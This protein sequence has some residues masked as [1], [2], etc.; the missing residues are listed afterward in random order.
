[1]EITR[2]KG[3]GEAKATALL[4]EFKTKKAMKE[5]TVEQLAEAA[6]VGREVAEELYLFIQET[7]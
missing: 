2:V 5:A 7:F 4:K 3:I 1:M 6:K